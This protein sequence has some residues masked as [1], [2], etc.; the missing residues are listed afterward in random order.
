MEDIFVSYSRKDG[1]K[2]HELKERLESLGYSVWIDKDD[3]RV[4]RLWRAQIV[5]GIEECRLYVIVL[6]ANSIKSDNVRRELDL[7]RRRK[8]KILP[9][10]TD[11]GPKRISKDMEYQLIGLQRI[12]YARCFEEGMKQTLLELI[13][14]PP[15]EEMQ[16]DDTLSFA[17]L[18]PQTGSAI[19]LLQNR[20]VVGRGPG[21]DVDLTEW[22]IERFVSKK[23]AELIREEGEWRLRVY[24][25]TSN[26][27]LVNGAPV[28]KGGE[29]KLQS[30]D[31][32]T[33]ASSRFKFVPAEDS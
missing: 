9:V 2:A 4:G 16:L 19:R 11:P 26:P 12:D 30:G 10:L 21:V 3:L 5:E 13:G 22:D 15:T 25:G 20:Q 17:L 31:E 29:V 6:S 1:A 23:H 8:K 27:T 32:I 33:F 7:A 24:E 18:E 28:A 14:A